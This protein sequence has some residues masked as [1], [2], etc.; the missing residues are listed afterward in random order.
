MVVRLALFAFDREIVGGVLSGN[1]FPVAGPMCPLQTERG[2]FRPLH[3]L[4]NS[5]LIVPIALG[6]SF[7]VT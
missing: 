1:R 2:D 5:N 3:Y 7:T 4:Q 6:A